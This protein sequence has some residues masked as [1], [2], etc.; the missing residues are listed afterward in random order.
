MIGGTG[1]SGT[2][3]VAQIARRAGL[4]IGRELHRSEDALGFI[5]F[6]DR[7]VDA[8]ARR[9]PSRFSAWSEARMTKQLSAFLRAHCA[10]SRPGAA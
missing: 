10:R 9:E 2:R 4:F 1:G 3:V 8:Y 6:A 5:K 7:W